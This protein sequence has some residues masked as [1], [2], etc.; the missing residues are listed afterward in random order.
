MRDITQILKLLF[1]IAICY[2]TCFG[3]IDTNKRYIGNL[4]IAADTTL[5]NLTLILKNRIS[6]VEIINSSKISDICFYKNDTVEMVIT[7]NGQQ[8][9]IKDFNKFFPYADFTHSV[10]IHLSKR[11]VLCTQIE[12]N[13]GRHGEVYMT[14]VNCK[15]FPDIDEY[16]N[17]I[18]IFTFGEIKRTHY[19]E[20]KN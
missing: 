15:N 1:L 2:D 11:N 6:K 4:T 9:I 19:T 14:D 10:T 16:S 18:S 3:Q 8:L 17:G 7:Y 20:L 13:D 5:S 12:H